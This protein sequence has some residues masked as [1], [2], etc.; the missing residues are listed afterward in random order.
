VPGH[1][2]VYAAVPRVPCAAQPVN[3]FRGTVRLTLPCRDAPAGLDVFAASADRIRSYFDEPTGNAVYLVGHPAHP[4]IRSDD[5]L[6]RWCG[7][8]VQD[9]PSALR[10]LIGHFV[11]IVDDR[12]R[13][14]VAFASDVLG[15]RPWF[16]GSFDGR[17]VGGTDV[18]GICDAGLSRGEA[19]PDAVS[20]WLNYNFDCT[21]GSVV[22]DYRRVADGAVSTYD[23][24]G[25][26]LGA[27]PY[28]ALRFEPNVVPPAE[29]VDAL[30]ERVAASF[31]RLVRGV[32]EAALPLSG[33]YDSRLLC[34]LA[35]RASRPRRLHL[36]TVAST[37]GE[38]RAAGPVAEAL[39]VRTEV[40]PVGPGGVAD[41]FDDPLSFS[42]EGFPTPRNLTSAVA[43]RRPGVPVIS[44]F[45]GDVLMR[46]STNA[47]VRRFRALD[48]HALDD[49][50]LTDAAHGRFR[51]DVNRLD[52]L[53]DGV[54]ARATARARAALTRVVQLGRAAGR[55]LA[56]ANLYL[57]HRLYFAGIFLSHLDVADARLPFYDWALL[58][59]HARHGVSFVGGE[60]ELLFRRHFPALAHVPH[61]SKLEPPAAPGKPHARAG[62]PTRHLRPWADRLLRDLLAPPGPT[63]VTPRKLLA[64]LPGALLAEGRFEVEISFLYKVRAFEERLRRANVRLDWSSI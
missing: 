19:D 30:H 54:G 51:I 41:L 3:P 38:A 60:Y 13:Q 31:D 53:R 45:M 63:A 7:R 27:R 26:L 52:L 50:A 12:R 58:D 33:G 23:R 55:P 20:S 56:F 9:D 22:R 18:L 64:R 17:L 39:G 36:S 46:G 35:V 57:R 16:V 44:G 48:D 2:E 40:L 15:V 49:A 10:Q 14:R 61:S 62:R 25:T 4:S 24:A 43:R 5:A 42:P 37:P 11:L 21:G 47:S 6:L 8:A 59:F 29:L 32:D 1:A 28:A 34:A